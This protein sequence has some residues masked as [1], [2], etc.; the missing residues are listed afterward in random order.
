M[1]EVLFVTNL[2]YKNIVYKLYLI[3]GKYE[4]ECLN[5]KVDNNSID[6]LKKIILSK[7]TMNDKIKNSKIIIPSTIIFSTGVFLGIILNKNI[8]KLK[9]EN[10]FNI[11]IDTIQSEILTNENINDFDEDLFLKYV[12]AI[13]SNPNLT[14]DDKKFFVERFKYINENKNFV[15]KQEILNTVN[16]IQIIRH[17]YDKGTIL[18]DFQIQEGIPT[19]NLYSKATEETLIH[20]IYHALKYNK[21]YW[22]TVYYY[23]GNF[24]GSDEYNLLSNEEKNQCEKK[25]IVGNMIEEAHTSILTAAEE[26]TENIN[27]PYYKEVYIYKIYEKIF[28]K[29]NME[30]NMLAPNQVVGFL[31]NLLSLGCTKEEAILITARLDLYNTLTYQQNENLDLSY[32]TYQIC[33]DLTFVYNKK[34]NDIND[35]LLNITILSLTNNLNFDITTEIESD[36][37]FPELFK[38]ISKKELT[39]NQYLDDIIIVNYAT[40]YG[41]N[42]IYIDYFSND[43]PRVCVEV[44]NYDKIILNIDGQDV[45]YFNT[46]GDSETAQ[47]IYKLYTDYYEFALNQYG[48]DSN[49]ACFFACIYANQSINIEQKA[50]LLDYYDIWQKVLITE[51]DSRK[52]LLL[53]DY[54]KIKSVFNNIIQEQE[55]DKNYLK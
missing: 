32:L 15:N 1:N 43:C 50:E 17:D 20:E 10:E 54:N 40:N 38:K 53:A 33:D 44:N 37:Y 47:Y 11:D 46:I 14:E 3:N 30:K 34:Y 45:T 26:D 55:L 6:E 9:I 25:N 4:I 24:I 39:I 42:N 41:V 16:K 12:S 29:E 2:I 7:H 13:Y 22:D 19:I 5:N 23:N 27:I 52:V 49:Y 36:F 8:E 28:G 18:G 21:Y 35:P 48:N 31:N 51:E